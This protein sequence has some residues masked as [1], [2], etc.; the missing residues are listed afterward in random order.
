MQGA[1]KPVDTAASEIVVVAPNTIQEG[2]RLLARSGNSGDVYYGFAPNVTT[3][4]GILL[5]KGNPGDTALKTIP[6]SHFSGGGKVYIVGSAASQTVDWE[7][8]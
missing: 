5:P 2:M 1:A 4:T 7:A 6:A 8:A 3:L